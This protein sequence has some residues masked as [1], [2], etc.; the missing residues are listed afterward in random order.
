ME[1]KTIEKNAFIDSI[2]LWILFGVLLSAIPTI[3]TVLY[4]L[5]VGLT[6]SYQ[7]CIPDVLLVVLAVC[8]NFINLCLDLKISYLFRWILC[9]IMS[10]IILFCWGMY[11]TVYFLPD[12][13]KKVF[14][15]ELDLSVFGNKLLVLFIF[16]IIIILFCLV[17]GIIIIYKKFKNTS[18]TQ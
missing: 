11:L 4:K 2:M 14:H 16:S 10:I 13:L 9:T 18:S 15:L 5:I 17:T 1:N 12:I 3:F 7:D 6:F 8:C